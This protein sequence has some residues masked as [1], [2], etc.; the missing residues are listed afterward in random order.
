ICGT[1]ENA[2]WSEWWWMSTQ[3]RA[4][5]AYFCICL[6]FGG[7]YSNDASNANNYVRPRFI[8]AIAES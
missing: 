7:A 3:A 6:N 2:E 5:A 4:S 1:S 8:L